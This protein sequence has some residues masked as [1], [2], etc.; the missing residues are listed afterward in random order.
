MGSSDAE[1]LERPPPEASQAAR[2]LR[3]DPP[4]AR[5]PA[6]PPAAPREAAA[7]PPP[8]DCL[9][10]ALEQ[11]P[12]LAA[13]MARLSAA[14][15][16]SETG[17]LEDLS[18]AAA[19]RRLP[20]LLGEAALLPVET[21]EQRLEAG[22]GFEAPALPT[23]WPKDPALRAQLMLHGMQGGCG[24]GIPNTAPFLWAH[25]SVEETLDEEGR[26]TA[27]P[28]SWLAD[29]ALFYGC[30]RPGPPWPRHVLEDCAD[31]GLRRL[32]AA[33]E[34]SQALDVEDLGHFCRLAR[35]AAVSQGLA[36]H[37]LY[38]ALAGRV[39][40]ALPSGP[41]LPLSAVHD[42]A[43]ALA[44]I[45]PW[46]ADCV[47]GAA[48]VSSALRA[49]CRAPPAPGAPP[50]PSSLAVVAECSQAGERLG[51]AK[52]NQD[53]CYTSLEGDS[54][55]LL[56]IDGHGK[57]GGSVAGEI[58]DLIKLQLP[59]LP[60]G[61]ATAKWLADALLAADA[62]ILLHPKIDPE[63]SGATVVVVRIEGLG[64][65]SRRLAVAHL[66]DCR[67]IMGRCED[68]G[69][70]ELRWVSQRLT[71]D[72]RPDDQQEAVRL[73]A[74]GGR[75]RKAP[76]QLPATSGD[77]GSK[78]R[79]TFESC[80][81][82]GGPSRLWH[83]ANG[84]TGPGLAM[85]RGLGD[86]LGKGCGLLAEAPCREV[87]LTEDD[88]VV[89]AASDGIFD[90]LSDAEVLHCCRYFWSSRNA[91]DA[92]AAVVAAATKGWANK[93]LSYRDDCTCAVLY[94]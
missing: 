22:E 29:V 91:A 61:T 13:F 79:L 90:V 52:K 70:G 5:L 31:E 78:P 57:R 46:D 42:L 53:V 87:L 17:K 67:A 39:A 38:G 43:L 71:E 62:A 58:R 35:G 14:G 12:T 44:L 66:G 10:A 73:L 83:R 27:V 3:A 4:Q 68:D 9:A 30:M 32:Q 26:R 33:A 86:T 21:L 69:A 84:G 19:L 93:G 40:A 65:R 45:R 56:M 85:S 6:G 8:M 41:A 47:R 7:Q 51:E 2:E 59:G 34:A 64:S 18:V 24:N 75:V 88:K 60:T 16:A 23:T 50:A 81:G 77:R 48:M 54:A 80:E 20:S 36:R 11:A 74:A 92:A 1:S 28:V 55:V 82:F 89:V 72:H 94:L 25:E 49:R 37:G 63:H 76:L 15:A